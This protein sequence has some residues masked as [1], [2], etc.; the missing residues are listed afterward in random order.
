MT[1][2]RASWPAAPVAEEQPESQRHDQ[3]RVHQ[4]EVHGGK[5]LEV[6]LVDAG[7]QA[8]LPD[9][10][11]HAEPEHQGEQD[12][13]GEAA[14]VAP[15]GVGEAGRQ[16]TAAPPWIGRSTRRTRA[17]ATRG[18]A[19]RIRVTAGI[20]LVGFGAAANHPGVRLWTDFQAL[21]S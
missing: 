10:G 11:E 5:A 9:G 20:L 1:T 3:Q 13:R 8:D 14:Q 6:D 2:V 21:I 18:S 17:P 7:R 19:K 16:Q 15:R 12:D 4:E